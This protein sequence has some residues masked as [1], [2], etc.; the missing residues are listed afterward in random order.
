MM[1]GCQVLS[2]KE[3]VQH[4]IAAFTE[5]HVH[6]EHTGGVRAIDRG[7]LNMNEIQCVL[8]PDGSWA[9]TLPHIH[10]PLSN[11]TYEFVYTVKNDF[12]TAK[13][14]CTSIN[15]IPDAR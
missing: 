10:L 12:T 6:S 2:E 11:L 13:Y 9:C 1:V 14:S 15:R 3:V 4:A 7:E 5:L 8:Q